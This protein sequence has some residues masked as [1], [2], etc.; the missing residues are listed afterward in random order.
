MKVHA[1]AV[2]A[3][4][5]PALAAAKQLPTE[6]SAASD[7]GRSL[8]SQSRRLEDG[9]D[10]DDMT[11]VAGYS[12]KFQGCHHY[13]SL[14]LDAD[15][16]DDVK[17]Q[18]SKLAHFRLCPSGSCQN[19]RGG[20]CSADYG[21]Y[22]V[23]LATF[24]KAFVEAQRQAQEFDCKTYVYENCDCTESDDKEDDF[25]RDY[26][27]YDCYVAS[28]KYKGCV[29]RNP[30]S[31]DE[32]EDRERENEVER[33]AECQELEL[34]ENDDA[35]RRLEEDEEVSYYV[36]P[37]CSE[38]GG[39][40]Y[41]GLYTDDTCTN[42]A[43]DDKGRTTYSDLMGSDLPYGSSSLITNDCISCVE[44]ED[45]ERQAERAENGEDEDEEV[46]LSRVCEESYE[47]AG[48][49]E[50]HLSGITSD[51]NEA[52]CSFIGGIKFTKENGILEVRSG[53]N[54]VFTFFI[55]AFMGI[56]IGLAAVVFKLKKQISDVK[57]KPLLETGE[58]QAEE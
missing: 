26:C 15:D 25:N 43:D 54:K 53:T 49:C 6:I 18:T 45:P 37:Y 5:A 3:A 29:D 51:V 31:D 20:G 44:Q 32:E 50:S 14:N 13:T 56:F 52:A 7:L 28:K 24:A 9:N 23:D 10:E 34:P 11:W 57:D 4:A 2:A 48:K 19:W 42:F 1:I 22:V 8:L 21:D 38:K 36:G 27:E 33:Y 47:G 55:C 17:V 40:V 12:L 41:L 30:Y 39:A 46:R 58:A 16:E 35:N